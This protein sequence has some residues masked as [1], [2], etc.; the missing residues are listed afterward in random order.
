VTGITS[1]RASAR[2]VLSGSRA[3]TGY[4]AR[5]FVFVLGELVRRINGRA[6]ARFIQEDACQPLGIR[7]LF[8]GIPPEVEP[9][10]E[11]EL[12]PAPS[13]PLPSDSLLPLV[14]PRSLP[15]TASAAV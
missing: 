15:P 12:V 5:T 10:M 7:D 8:F 11:D 2:S 6:F 9:R 1:A 4:H 3:R 13:P 14:F